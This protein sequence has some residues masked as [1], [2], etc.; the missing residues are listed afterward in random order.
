MSVSGDILRHLPATDR[1][2]RFSFVK[3]IAWAGA[4]TP[5][6]SLLWTGLNEGYGPKPVTF[7]THA[8][9]DAA[10]W[11]LIA[12]LA[13]SPLRT[14]TRWNPLINSRRI[15]GNFALA[16]ALAHVAVFVWSEGVARAASEIVLRFYLTIGFAA[17]AILV[18][19]GATS[20]DGAVKRLGAMGWR[21]VHRWIYVAT[22]LGLLHYF[23]QS[24]ND[25]TPALLQ[26]GFFTLLMLWRALD[27]ARRG[28]D[29]IWLVGLALVAG[30][31]TAAIEAAW[32]FWRSG[33]PPLDVMAANLDFDLDVRP[34]WIVAA[35]G[36]AG[37]GLS[38]FRRR[39]GTGRRL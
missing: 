39:T 27:A 36:L 20:N 9:G 17:L 6:L 18:M 26:A 25:V 31:S 37:A 12:T 22:A 1:A 15:L 5:G 10:V 3:A 24:K 32:Y 28:A 33:L 4:A 8:L 2:G 38:L 7:V 11:L 21:R 19:L 14:I 35:A 16:Y 13:V 23:L 34:P 30:L 29:T